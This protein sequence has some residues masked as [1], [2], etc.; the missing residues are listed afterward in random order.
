MNFV[1]LKTG[2]LGIKGQI[3]KSILN[4]LDHGKFIMGPEVYE[5]EEKLAEYVGV[6]HAIC[7]SSGTDALQVAMMALGV[8]YGDEVITSP[9]TFIATAE[10]IALTGATPVF[11]DIDPKTY[12]IDPALIEAAITEKTKAIMPVSLYGQCADFEAINAVADK[13]GIPVIEDGAQSFGATYN[14]KKS[15][16]LSTIGATSFYPSK[17]LGCYGDGGASFTSDSELANKMKQ[18]RD[19]GQDRRYNHA[20]IG[21]NA[22]MDTIQAAILLEKLAIYPE[23]LKMR[24]AVG[25]RYTKLLDGVI[26]TPEVAKG[27]SHVYAQYT[28]R[29][30]M[31][32]ELITKL[33]DR[34]IPTA[35]HYPVPLH[36]QPVFKYLN[37]PEGAFPVSEEM[38]RK[39]MSLPMHPYLT[40]REQA[41]VADAIKHIIGQV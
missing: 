26:P 6:K 20:L 31:R 37:Q 10:T 35:I 36:L 5:L 14:G 12:N 4:V 40:E 39:V 21:L 7:L 25:S 11:V 13:H 1:D 9:F 28:I 29:S 15:C 2:Y 38:S 17:P 3:D 41:Q 22:R 8:G 16:G 27:C 34:A 23:E 33:N 19:H 30:P 24:G 18:I 32:D